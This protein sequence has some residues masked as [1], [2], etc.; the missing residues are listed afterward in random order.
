MATV[1]RGF[2]QNHSALYCTPPSHLN[3]RASHSSPVKP[4]TFIHLS[5]APSTPS[6]AIR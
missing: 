2:Y 1:M 5:G 4:S 3:F 6:A